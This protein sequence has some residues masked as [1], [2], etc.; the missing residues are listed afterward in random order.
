MVT[1]RRKL[2]LDSYSID[3]PGH[4]YNALFHVS[5]WLP[6]LLDAVGHYSLV[7]DANL[8]GVSQWSHLVAAGSRDSNDDDDHDHAQATESWPRTEFLYNYGRY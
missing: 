7:E 2:S 5:D 1:T 3:V 8:D 4:Q 6:T